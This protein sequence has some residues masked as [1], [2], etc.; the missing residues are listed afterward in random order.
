MSTEIVNTNTDAKVKKIT[1]AAK[2]AKFMVF[3]H[4]FIQRLNADETVTAAARDTLLMFAS[5]EDQNQ[6]FDLFFS[7]LKTSTAEMKTLIKQHNK[8]PPKPKKNNAKKEPSDKKIKNNKAKKTID[9]ITDPQDALVAEIVAAAQTEIAPGA[10]V[11]TVIRKG[12]EPTVHTNLPLTGEEVVT[13]VNEEPQKKVEPTVPHTTLPTADT[14]TITQEKT[15]KK[16]VVKKAAKATTVEK[17]PDDEKKP[18][19]NKANEDAK[20][21]EAETK[22]AAKAL[23]AETKKAAK[24]QAKPAE[25]KDKPAKKE[26]KLVNTKPA[27]PELASNNPEGMGLNGETDGDDD[28]LNLRPIQFPDGKTFLLDES[29][30]LLYDPES[31]HN[32]DFAPVAF[33]KENKWVSI[34]TK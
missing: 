32:D 3:G 22:K 16:K 30:N 34:S 27:E 4:W 9:V 31:I 5:P 33:Y 6:M 20:A 24:D 1:L 11:R 8:P 18:A 2:Y 29:T 7:K 19:V 25:K 15:P 17:L 12:G 23:E 10:E 13:D 26:K 14:V 28:T 21:L